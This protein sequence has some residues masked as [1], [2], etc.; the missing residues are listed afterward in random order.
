MND[1]NDTP[2]SIGDWMLTYL[3]M[4]IPVVGFILL[5]VW[6]FGGNTP[7]SKANWAKASLIWGVIV[8]AIY[9]VMFAMFGAA[10]IAAAAA[11]A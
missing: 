11:G 9:A 7:V 8:I 10:I 6:A 1:T 5:L 2:V 3:L 4:G